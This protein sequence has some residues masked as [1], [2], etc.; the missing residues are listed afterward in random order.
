MLQGG[1]LAPFGKKH[2]Y[3]LQTKLEG[4]K[5]RYLARKGGGVDALALGGGDQPKTYHG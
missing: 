1:S 3:I 4:K 5:T 2:A